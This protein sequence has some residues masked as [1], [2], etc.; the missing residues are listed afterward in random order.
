MG[1]ISRETGTR[2]IS[3]GEHFV[4]KREVEARSTI[5]ILNVTQML[6]TAALKGSFKVIWS[7]Q[8]KAD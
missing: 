6:P 3:G 2:Y 1:A 5:Q 8:L 4:T 7:P